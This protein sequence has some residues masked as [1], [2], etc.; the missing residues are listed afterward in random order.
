MDAFLNIRFLMFLPS[1]S[2][3]TFAQ[4]DGSFFIFGRRE[5]WCDVKMTLLFLMIKLKT[6]Q[7][8]YTRVGQVT[9]HVL[10]SVRANLQRN[11]SL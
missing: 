9:C 6:L 2:V 4:S 3:L 5:T 11:Y 8:V 7:T 1:F 10:L